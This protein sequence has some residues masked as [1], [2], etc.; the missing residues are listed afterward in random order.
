MLF[1]KIDTQV[2]T[3]LIHTSHMLSI[4]QKANLIKNT[5]KLFNQN[6]ILKTKIK[7]RSN[8]KFVVFHNLVLF[9]SLPN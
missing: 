4:Y 8:L 6:H 2:D 5:L 9:R 1:I 3:M 7:R